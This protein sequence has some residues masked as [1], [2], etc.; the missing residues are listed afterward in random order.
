VEVVLVAVSLVALTAQMVST[1]HS[2][3]LLHQSVA[4]VV[5]LI[6]LPQVLDR[7]ALAVVLVVVVLLQILQQ[8]L[9]VLVHQVKVMLEVLVET[10][11]VHIGL[12]AVA[13][14]VQ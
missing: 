7:M 13:V 1:H 4:V 6:L 9:A 8:K 2:V 11:L 12:E 5:E 10:E 14:L 3:R